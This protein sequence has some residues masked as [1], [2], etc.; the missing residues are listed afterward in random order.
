ME[1][2]I[3]D[4]R[5]YIGR[6]LVLLRE[7]LDAFIYQR[8]EFA[9]TPITDHTRKDVFPVLRWLLE[10][11]RS[12][13]HKTLGNEGCALLKK[14]KYVRNCW[15]H[16]HD[17]SLEEAT[18][19]IKEIRELLTIMGSQRTE[20]LG[21]LEVN[22]RGESDRILAFEKANKEWWQRWNQAGRK[23]FRFIEPPPTA[24]VPL[25]VPT[26]K[27]CYL[28]SAQVNKIP[29]SVNP[30]TEKFV[31]TGLPD[32]CSVCKTA[33]TEGLKQELADPPETWDLS[34]IMVISGAWGGPPPISD[35]TEF[36]REKRVKNPS[37]VLRGW[38]STIQDFADK[39]GANEAQL[40][41]HDESPLAAGI[42]SS[43]RY[44]SLF[45]Q[46]D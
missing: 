15:A 27:Q 35:L 13:S 7:E 44:L 19:S 6:A 38:R 21:Q 20:D 46:D 10:D 32:V 22:L 18:R 11:A 28:C 41:V 43:V 26:D 5:A 36:L 30:W 16:Q 8:T 4:T 45:I 33:Q 39:V 42:N 31:D 3:L 1:T 29:K 34:I 17:F 14:A 23:C 24:Y 40:P 25:L 9:N 2:I 12:A 37:E